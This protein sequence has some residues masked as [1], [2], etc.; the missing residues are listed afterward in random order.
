MSKIRTTATLSLLAAMLSVPAV[1]QANS[2]W[3]PAPGEQGFTFHP[4]HS[5]STKTR[6]EVLRELEQAKADGSYFYLQR[7]L[8]VPS[9]VSGP[10]KTREE[11]IKELTNMTPQERRYMN[12]LY[13]GS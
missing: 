3:H 9:R 11:V 10:G 1:V 6:A 7:G 2:L 13:R 8:P 12:D 4:D 5:T